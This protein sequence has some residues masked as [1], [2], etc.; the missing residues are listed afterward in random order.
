MAYLIV[1]EIDSEEH[2]SPEAAAAWAL[3]IQRDPSSHA[4]YFKVID[5]DTNETTEVDLAY[6]VVNGQCVL[7]G[8]EYDGVERGECF[9]GDCPPSN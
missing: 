1:W 9:A 5:Q 2:D 8:R 6:P 4:T 3:K 7:C